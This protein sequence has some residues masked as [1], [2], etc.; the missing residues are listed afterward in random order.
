[1]SLRPPGASRRAPSESKPSP[2]RER[3]SA[4]GA[5]LKRLA[6]RDLSEA[7]MRAALSSKGYEGDEI[8][9]AIAR[10][11][12]ERLLS[13]PRLA[14]RVA[15]RRMES[16]GLGR[17]RVRQ[18]L[19]RRGV[20]PETLEAGLQRALQE[21]SEPAVLERVAKRYWAANAR[22]PP[23]KR[24]RRLYAFLLRRGFPQSLVGQAIR[25]LFPKVEAALLEELS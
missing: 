10:L 4:Y 15:V 19:E 11:G 22:V 20:A 23:P 18:E 7:E 1:V 12:R 13:D 17:F 24:V 5:G 25:S 9:E 2:P 16:S 14:E 21:V 8:D 6:L 3:P